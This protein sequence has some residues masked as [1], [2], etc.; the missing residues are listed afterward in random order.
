M[1]FI[2][3]EKARKFCEISTLLLSVCSVEKSKVKISQNFA[4][5]LEYTNFNVLKVPKWEPIN[6]PKLPQNLSAQIVCL[7]V[8]DF[9]EKRLHWA[10]LVP[11]IW[12]SF[13]IKSC[14]LA[15]PQKISCLLYVSKAYFSM[16]RISMK[17]FEELRIA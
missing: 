8:W 14:V 13:S 1:K 11:T 2:Y 5:F 16:E 4:T 17:I 9:D 7:R 3:S 6:R 12:N 15:D 10:S